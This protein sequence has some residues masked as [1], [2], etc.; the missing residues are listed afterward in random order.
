MIVSFS[1]AFFQVG[2]E[3]LF[4]PIFIIVFLSAFFQWSLR[5]SKAPYIFWSLLSILSDFSTVLM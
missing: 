2:F 5:D 1:I 4:V 3:Y